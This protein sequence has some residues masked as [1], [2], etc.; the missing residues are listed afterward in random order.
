MDSLKFHLDPP[1]PTLLQP[2]G[3]PPLKGPYSCFRGIPHTGRA[4]CSHLQFYPFEN[5]TP[6]AYAQTL[7]NQIDWNR[8]SDKKESK[9]LK[10]FLYS[11]L[12]VVIG[13]AG[14]YLPAS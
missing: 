2:A 14:G 4:A 6:Y 8:K 10:R 11:N 9:Y 5:P 13:C 3:E 12:K 7:G 1:C